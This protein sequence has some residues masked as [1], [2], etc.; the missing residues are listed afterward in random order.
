MQ[1]ICKQC[2][3]A[4]VEDG[5]QFGCSFD[6]RLDKYIAKGIAAKKDDWFFTIETKCEAWT[7]SSVGQ[8]L[9]PDVKDIVRKSITPTVDA[10]VY[11]D[12]DITVAILETIKDDG[13]KN[14]IVCQPNI[15]GLRSYRRVSEIFPRVITSSQIDN[16]YELEYLDNGCFKSKSSYLAVINSPTIPKIPET[17]TNYVMNELVDFI[18]IMSDD[19]NGLVIKPKIYKFLYGNAMESIVNK[20][21][22]I[23]NYESM[24]LKWNTQE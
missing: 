20:I 16:R 17:V 6:D 2:I 14:I 23:P 10:I 15:I 22:S 24:T 13:Y 3:F 18:G 9:P 12:D 21:K 19:M 8:I 7:T 11:G 4:K 5:N 1:T